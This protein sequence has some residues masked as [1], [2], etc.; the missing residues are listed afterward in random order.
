[1]RL[2]SV[3]IVFL[4]CLS[5][6]S[7]TYSYADNPEPKLEVYINIY[8][9]VEEDTIQDPGEYPQNKWHYYVT[10]QDGGLITSYN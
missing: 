9:L 6:Y 4:I 5:L 2:K 7:C 10:V 3:L 8:K 1:M